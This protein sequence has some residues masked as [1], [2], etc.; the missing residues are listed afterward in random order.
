M[1]IIIKKKS[2]DEELLDQVKED[3]GIYSALEMA[4]YFSKD[5]G[6]KKTIWLDQGAKNRPIP[7]N[8]RRVKYGGSQDLTIAFD[9]NGNC[10][11]IGS[12]KKSDFSDLDKVFEWIKLNIKALNK[13]YNGQDENGQTYNIDNFEQERQS[14]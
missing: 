7:H 13:L 12:Y 5:T 14:I 11:V 6:L 1:K 4:N 10:K 9:E 8:K 3:S 2:F